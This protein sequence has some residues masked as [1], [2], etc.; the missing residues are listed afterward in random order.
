[1]L[2]NFHYIFCTKYGSLHHQSLTKIVQT[3][4]HTKLTVRKKRAMARKKEH[5]QKK[6]G[7]G[8]KKKGALGRDC[9]ILYM[10]RTMT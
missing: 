4:K 7:N 6:K 10:G 2:L 3:L 5:V 8:Q 1:M 9:C